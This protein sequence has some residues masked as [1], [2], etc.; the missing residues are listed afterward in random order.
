MEF[1]R[2][3]HKFRF[4]ISSGSSNNSFLNFVGTLQNLF[5]EFRV[6]EPI[7]SFWNFVGRGAVPPV[8]LF[9]DHVG[10]SKWPQ[11]HPS[12]C[13]GAAKGSDGR[14]GL[15]NRPQMACCF[16]L[17][18]P[19]LRIAFRRIAFGMTSP[20]TPSSGSDFFVEKKS[21][22][23]SSVTFASEKIHL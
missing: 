17:L 4:G 18:A 6:G 13:F 15:Q 19:L 16:V 1:R 12:H 5:L 20:L 9:W 21:F 7:I 11:E 23:F 2:G 10:A 14:L 3:N 8:H 22:G